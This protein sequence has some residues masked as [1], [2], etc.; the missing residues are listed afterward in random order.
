[1]TNSI[2]ITLNLSSIRYIQINPA[3]RSRNK[4]VLNSNGWEGEYWNISINFPT[5][6]FKDSSKEVNEEVSLDNIIVSSF[7]SKDCDDA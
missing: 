2:F 4:D 5:S 3:K 6:T 7:L 1:M